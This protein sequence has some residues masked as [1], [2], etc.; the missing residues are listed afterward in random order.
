MSDEFRTPSLACEITF[1]IRI[2]DCSKTSVTYNIVQCTI[3]Q[4]LGICLQSNVKEVIV[5]S[6]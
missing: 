4:S 2:E 6:H 1:S 5:E 3:S